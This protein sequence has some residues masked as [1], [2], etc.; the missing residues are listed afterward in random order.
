[1]A[2]LTI[3][4]NVNKVSTLFTAVK[5][6]F[7]ATSPLAKWLYK[8]AVAPPGDADNNNKPTASA[9]GKSNKIAIPKHKIG[10]SIIWH[11]KPMII[12]LG[13]VTTRLKSAK[14]KLKPSPSMII[15]KAIGKNNVKIAFCSIE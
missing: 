7:K 10:K 14:V 8:L 9:G 5:E 12:A 4:G 1:M 11:N 2:K 13:K 6:M 3:K 15:P